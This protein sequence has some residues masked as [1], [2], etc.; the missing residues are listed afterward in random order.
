[1]VA[2]AICISGL[3]ANNLYCPLAVDTTFHKT[4]RSRWFARSRKHKNSVARLLAVS[5]INVRSSNLVD[6]VCEP[7]G[8]RVPQTADYV[9]ITQ[10]FHFQLH[11]TAF[12]LIELLDHDH[13]A[14]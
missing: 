1:M 7:E 4:E 11:E 9:T 8:S 3:L 14:F 5:R 10:I 2:S 6:R 12:T 13:R